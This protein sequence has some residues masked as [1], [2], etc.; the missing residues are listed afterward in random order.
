[1][2]RPRILLAD[3]HKATLEA[4][5]GMLS[6]EFEVVGTVCNGREVVSAAAR[7]E[8]DLIVLDIAMPDMNGLVAARHMKD[9]GSQIPVVFLSVHEEQ[10][11]VVEAA[12]AGGLGYVFKARLRHDLPAAI[13]AALAGNSFVSSNGDTPL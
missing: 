5:A 1:M 13:S 3:D 12:N 6:A 10:D 9:H 7:F 4:V 11:F 2:A 8:P